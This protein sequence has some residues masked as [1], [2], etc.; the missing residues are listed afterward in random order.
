MGRKPTIYTAK[1]NIRLHRDLLQIVQKA[2]EKNQITVA[3]QI[4]VMLEEG[5]EPRRT[6]YDLNG[7][8]EA[9]LMDRNPHEKLASKQIKIT[10]K[11][12]TVETME[13]Y[14]LLCRAEVREIRVS[15]IVDYLEN[16]GFIMI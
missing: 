13:Q 10:L 16:N 9:F 7:L 6:A 8:T 14:A 4:A 11:P 3:R 2:A 1:R 15:L 5:T 12:S